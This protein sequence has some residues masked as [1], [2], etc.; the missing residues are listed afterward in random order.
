MQ[1]ILDTEV[2]VLNRRYQPV[3]VATVRRALMLLCEGGALALDASLVAHDF[4]RWVAL[5][6]DDGREGERIITPRLALWVPRVI[7]LREYDRLPQRRLR[8]SRANIYAR[9]GHRC[10]YCQRT[11]HRSLLN[12]DH[13][14]PRAQGGGNSWDNLV[15]SCIRCNH[16]KGGRTPEEAGMRLLRRPFAPRWSPVFRPPSR[17]YAE[18]TAFLSEADTACWDDAPSMLGATG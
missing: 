16:R 10:Q 2:L 5:S 11:F 14:V 15:C 4:S 1:A 8:L 9:D 17:R 7:V 18:W 3:H 6:S 13:V 12:L